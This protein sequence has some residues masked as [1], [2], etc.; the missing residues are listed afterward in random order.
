MEDRFDSR[1][2]RTIL[3]KILRQE[4][5]VVQSR[6]REKE[7][8]NSILSDEKARTRSSL[9]R[10]QVHTWSSRLVS[11]QLV[12]HAFRD[13]REKGRRRGR[14]LSK[15]GQ[16]CFE[17]KQRDKFFNESISRDRNTARYRTRRR[18]KC[19]AVSRAKGEEEK[20]IN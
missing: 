15:R 1:F 3:N 7:M 17:L 6:E 13:V 14:A 16:N 11:C 8:R 9:V 4:T 18:D 5:R 12:K 10:E 20:S 19:S 2:P